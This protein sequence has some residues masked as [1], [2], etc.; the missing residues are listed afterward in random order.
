MMATFVKVLVCV[1]AATYKPTISSQS[2]LVNPSWML[3]RKL[4]NKKSVLLT[5]DL[6]KKTFWDTLKCCLVKCETEP[7]RICNTVRNDVPVRNKANDL[8]V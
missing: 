7:R 1:T 3:Q 4:T 8:Q 6:H 2:E 5:C